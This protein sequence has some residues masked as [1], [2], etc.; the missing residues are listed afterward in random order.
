[1]LALG[2]AARHYERN[3]QV[4]HHAL[5]DLGQASANLALEAAARGLC[6]H[7]M[8]GILSEPAR[9]LYAI[10]ED[11]EVCTALAIGYPDDTPGTGSEFKKQDAARRGRK[12]IA[13]FVFGPRW[14]TAADFA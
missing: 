7:Q 9:Q 4:N 3:G 13:E 10:P 1:M 14:G 8:G 11:F 6:V 2:V 12:P 5:H